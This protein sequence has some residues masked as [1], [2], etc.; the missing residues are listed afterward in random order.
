MGDSIE[1]L[2]ELLAKLLQTFRKG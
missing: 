1:S 2:A